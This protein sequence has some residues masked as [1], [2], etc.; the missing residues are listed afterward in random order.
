M[1]GAM[2]MFKTCTISITIQYLASSSEVLLD[3]QDSTEL[4]IEV[5]ISPILME[6]FGGIILV[7]DVTLQ[8]KES[9]P[10]AA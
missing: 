10:I 5:G 1:K 7:D 6:L 4:A 3:D 2:H 8:E 9:Q